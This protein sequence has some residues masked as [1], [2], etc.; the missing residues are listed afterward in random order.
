MITIEE[1]YPLTYNRIN[2][3]LDEIVDAGHSVLTSMR[4]Q[5]SRLS[6]AHHRLR[7]VKGSVSFG[8]SVMRMIERRSARDKYLFYALIGFICIVIV[9]S[10]CY[11]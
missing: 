3:T 7:D 1:D 4:E 5:G 8:E 11:L 2:A 9:L 10:F 6:G